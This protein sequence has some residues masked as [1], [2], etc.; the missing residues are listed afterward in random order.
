MGISGRRKRI[1]R[2]QLS[3]DTGVKILSLPLLRFPGSQVPTRLRFPGSQVPTR[4]RFPKSGLAGQS[5]QGFH[6]FSFTV[7]N[8]AHP[9]Q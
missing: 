5:V 1:C 3:Y 2:A 4:L 8:L 9:L 7:S 6:S